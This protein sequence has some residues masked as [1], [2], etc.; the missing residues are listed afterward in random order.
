MK[1]DKKMVEQFQYLSQHRARNIINYY[2]KGNEKVEQMVEI[3][4]EQSITG[5]QLKGNFRRK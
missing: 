5:F 2:W 1:G 3:V 4:K